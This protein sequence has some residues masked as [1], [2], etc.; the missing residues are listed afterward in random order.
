MTVELTDEQHL[1]LSGTASSKKIE[2]KLH[3]LNREDF[4]LIN[5]GYHWVNELPYNR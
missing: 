2:V 4:L 3:K 5:R 1:A